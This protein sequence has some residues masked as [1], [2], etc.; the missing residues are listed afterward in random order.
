MEFKEGLYSLE[1]YKRKQLFL[2]IYYS[3]QY[4][5]R[6]FYIAYDYRQCDGYMIRKGERVLHFE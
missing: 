1:K 3:V 2:F 5:S 4:F 6:V